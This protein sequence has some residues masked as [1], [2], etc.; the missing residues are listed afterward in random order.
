ML[1]CKT[2]VKDQSLYIIDARLIGLTVTNGYPFKSNGARHGPGVKTKR[3]FS[4][5]PHVWPTV[6]FTDVQK[7]PNNLPHQYLN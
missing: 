4:L 7:A 1:F 5:R 3:L 2:F 6:K